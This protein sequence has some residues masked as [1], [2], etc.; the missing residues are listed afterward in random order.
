MIDPH[1]SGTNALYR[2]DLG[3]SESNGSGGHLLNAHPRLAC[4]ID[5]SRFWRSPSD[6]PRWARPALLGIAAIC[7]LTYSWGIGN[8]PLEPFYGAAVR[9]MGAS[10][11]DF[12]FGAVDPMGTTSLDKLPGAFWVQALFVRVFGF[13]YWVVCLPQVLAGV[14]TVLVLFRA[15][16]RVAG[17]KAGLVASA[18]M[19]VSP[20][21]AIL[22]RGNVSDP[23]L[24]L[25]IVLAADAA[26][27]AA[28]TGRLRALLLCG[29]WVG[30]AF[31]TKMLQ[32][33]LVLPAL[34]GVY[35]LASPVTFRRRLLHVGASLVVVAM[36]SLSW[37]TAISIVPAKSRPYVDGTSNDS[38]FTQVFVYNGIARLGIDTHGGGIVGPPEPF[39]VRVEKHNNVVGTFQIPSSWHRLLGGPLGRDDA[40]LLPAAVACA[41]GVLLDRRRTGRRDPERTAA[42]LWSFWLVTL[43]GFFSG[44]SIVNSYYTGALVPPVA[45]LC[46]M[47]LRTAWHRRQRGQWLYLWLAVVA[48]GTAAYAVILLPSGA[49]I[50]WWLRPVALA[51]GVAACVACGDALRRVHARGD[52]GVRGASSR[53]L[54]AALVACVTVPA[55]V[56]F[57][58]PLFDL[59]SFSTPLQTSTATTGAVLKPQQYQTEGY[60]F[61]ARIDEEYPPGSIVGANDTAALSDGQIMVTGREYMPIGGFGGSEPA[62]SLATLR[63]LVHS[64]RLRFFQVPIT[65]PGQDPRTRWVRDNCTRQDSFHYGERVIIGV[66]RCLS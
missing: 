66:Y 7:A 19:A 41:A 36:V 26:L 62:P 20:A 22:N 1:D 15:V 53:A 23:L 37:M 50:R 28:L 29:L 56:V 24:V 10:W 63:S 58:V 51:L 3:W 6:Q 54:V 30:L 60:A 48:G 47:G 14:L 12:F 18:V 17:P 32:A 21:T 13:H 11:H 55:V 44:G 4:V 61:S 40:W 42:L 5:R 25:L 38:I 46:A 8:L 64:G 34:L 49:G 27:R 2:D 31:Q 43:L 35:L 52:H 9:S 57:T 45:A 33:W 65:P 59:G 16:R 39:L